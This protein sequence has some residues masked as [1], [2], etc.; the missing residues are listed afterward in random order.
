VNKDLTMIYGEISN[1][2]SFRFI[3]AGHPAPV[4][5]PRRFGK[6]MKISPD[7]TVA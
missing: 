6:I 7:R 1:L 3:S 4:V 5:F 2:G